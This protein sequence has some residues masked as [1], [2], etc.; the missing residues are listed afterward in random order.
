MA[1]TKYKYKKHLCKI[2]LWELF[3]VVIRFPIAKSI[4]LRQNTLSKRDMPPVVHFEWGY[5][6]RMTQIFT[7]VICLFISNFIYKFQRHHS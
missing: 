5:K 2:C 4:Y 6:D 1:E 7:V 3:N